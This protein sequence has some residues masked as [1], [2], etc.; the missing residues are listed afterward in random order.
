MLEAQTKS[1]SALWAEKQL[2]VAYK[3]VCLVV[4]FVIW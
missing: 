3:F 4:F 2:Y 1:L